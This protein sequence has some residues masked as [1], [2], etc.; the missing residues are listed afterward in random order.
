MPK[1]VGLSLLLLTCSV[2][3]AQEESRHE[4][5]PYGD[6]VSEA[7]T[8]L[9][10]QDEMIT[11]SVTSKTE[12]G[13]AIH[14]NQFNLDG[15]PPDFYPPIEILHGLGT[16][17]VRS[18]LLVSDLVF[19]DGLVL[20]APVDGFSDD[21][22]ARHRAILAAMASHRSVGLSGTALSAPISLKGFADAYRQMGRIC[23]FPTEDLAGGQRQ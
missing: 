19:D 22:K 3:N 16:A 21:G 10:E 1:W 11:C 2:A 15:G 14:V 6:W 12:D 8:V 4:S 13:V 5:W 17:G 7:E 23:G 18:E 20:S 9:G